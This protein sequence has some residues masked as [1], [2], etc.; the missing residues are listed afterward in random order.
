MPVVRRAS[1]VLLLVTLAASASAQVPERLVG[2]VPLPAG[3]REA[4]P[5]PL[6]GA[7][8]A[9]GP[10]AEP[11]RR[12]ALPP[13]H[14][15]G[16]SSVVSLDTPVE[17]DQ[18]TGVSVSPDG[19]RVVA[20]GFTT[21]NVEARTPAGTVLW[22][23]ADAGC[24]PYDVDDRGG[25]VV[26][27]CLRGLRVLVIDGATGAVRARVSTGG[28]AVQVRLTANGARAFV[29]VWAS[30]GAGSVV[31]VNTATGSLG[32]TFTVPIG[33]SGFTLP[34]ESNRDRILFNPFAVSDDGTRVAHA[35]FTG[36]RIYNGTTGALLDTQP[37]GWI[38]DALEISTDRSTLL[39]VYAYDPDGMPGRAVFYNLE[40][41]AAAVVPFDAPAV[42]Q[43]SAALAP[44]GRSALVSYNGVPLVVSP[45]Q[46]PVGA[47]GSDAEVFPLGQ[48][49]AAIQSP[50]Q[51]QVFDL[52]TRTVVAT[53]GSLPTLFPARM[54][55]GAT[56]AGTETLE[57]VVSQSAALGGIRYRTGA[58]PE[59]DG[60]RFVAISPDGTRIAISHG[61][62]NQVQIVDDTT[63]ETVALVDVGGI[64]AGMAFLPSGDLVVAAGSQL[65][66]L[67]P[68]TGGILQ[69]L[70]LPASNSRTVTVAGGRVFVHVPGGT[71]TV[72]VF[73]VTGGALVFRTSA[74]VKSRY[75]TNLG[76]GTV[77]FTAVT[78]DGG[79]VIGS[80][81]S[82]LSVLVFDVETE[83]LTPVPINAIGW[84]LAVSTDGT[85]ALVLGIDDRRVH[86]LSL[87]STPA[88]LAS[89]AVPGLLEATA[90]F[91]PVAGGFWVGA[92]TPG[93]LVLQLVDAQTGELVRTRSLGAYGLLGGLF[94]SAR[95]G[96]A[97]SVTDALQSYPGSPVSLATLGRLITER[98]TLDLAGAPAQIAGPTSRGEVVVAVPGP[99]LLA[100]A[101]G[102]P[103]AAEASP[104]VAALRVTA[105]GSPSRGPVRVRLDGPAQ[106]ALRV[107]A[108]DVLGRVVAR[109]YDGPFS[110]QETLQWDGAA[111]GTYVIRVA[112]TAVSAL[113][114]VVR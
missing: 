37:A 74:P 23:V 51:V 95:T 29:S 49:R 40:T 76:A 38:P 75:S 65:L 10:L 30:G 63:L 1:L 20:V 59:P 68:E 94:W 100:L 87:G 31:V 53:L 77:A 12:D 55:D 79:T 27:A 6:G 28:S 103:V 71:G 84:G 8:V 54:H 93:G 45:G 26:V 108:L 48:G 25:V 97:A 104:D 86:L 5:R 112:G 81:P 70:S 11:A 99:D 9:I 50:G 82:T 83:V 58:A 46:P 39:A 88:L 90:V 17:V 98:V 57:E 13:T 52:A 78:P 111:P 62:S 80:Q 32:T 43:A 69:T 18:I 72:E 3:M 110:G 73:D 16:A 2:P 4:L 109:L 36:L 21:S 114:V 61:I 24:G 96:V 7:R 92:N 56:L 102:A 67:N 15:G 89:K 22:T 14:R 42:Y 106:P 64:A 41:G 44:N 105:L 35:D 113:V 47:P 91:D 101:A 66:R 33:T 19:A 60:A 34:F 85:R 107:E